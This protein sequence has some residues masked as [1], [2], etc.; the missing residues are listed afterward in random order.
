VV[1]SFPQIGGNATDTSAA[2]CLDFLSHGSSNG[3][4]QLLEL[5][6]HSLHLGDDGAR[7]LAAGF[8]AGCFHRIQAL[9]L[10]HNDLTC[11]GC[12]ILADAIDKHPIPKIQEL[13]LTGNQI[14]DEGVRA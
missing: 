6:V 1:L 8:E 11:Q 12:E 9:D 5:S 4:Y 14:G 7:S 10:S 13:L 3:R 2:Q